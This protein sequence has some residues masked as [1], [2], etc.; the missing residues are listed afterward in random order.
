[1]NTHSLILTIAVVASLVLAMA[2]CNVLPEAEATRHFMLPQAAAEAPA[3][4]E[5]A[6]PLALRVHSPQASRILGSSRIAVVPDENEISSYRGARWSEPVPNLLRD[7]IIEAFQRDGR[8]ATVFD[9]QNRLSADLELFSKLGAFQSEYV[10][11]KALVRIQLDVQLTRAG[12]RELIASRRFEVTEESPAESIESV[13]ASFGRAGD[14]LSGEL[15]EW[16]MAQVA[17]FRATSKGAASTNPAVKQIVL[18][19]LT[20]RPRNAADN[21]RTRPS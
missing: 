21:V 13:V 8:L 2:A 18:I 5:A 1:M 4:G 20:G 19:C 12:G 9:E 15:L 7:R 11:G 17:N 16:T 14:R 6:F 10:N 3:D